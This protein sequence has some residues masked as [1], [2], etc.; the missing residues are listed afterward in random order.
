M[1]REAEAADA[2][3]GDSF[4]GQALIDPTGSGKFSER[5]G[6]EIGPYQLESVIGE[7]GFG[8]VWLARQDK[9]ISRQVAIKVI[10]AGMDTKEVL[11]RFD[12]ER[13][14]LAF[15]PGI[16]G[17]LGRGGR[18]MTP[19]PLFDGFSDR[20]LTIDGQEIAFWE[21]GSGPAILLLHGFPQCRAMWARIAPR[22]VAA[23]HRVIAADLRG[24]G[25][26]GQPGWVA[27]GH[28]HSFRAMGQ[29]MAGLMTA[30]GEVRFHVV[31]HDRGARVAHRMALDHAGR[32]RSVTLMDILPTLRLLEGFDLPLAR[33]YWH[34]TFLAQPEPF[35]EDLIAADPDRFFETCLL[36][37]G[38]ARPEDFD[39]GQMAAYRAAWRRS[40]V[41]SGMCRDYRATLSADLAHDRADRGR[42]IASPALILW[43]I[44]GVMARL[45][46]V[47]AEW[48]PYC[49]A[50][51]GE[52]LPGGHFFPDECP[53]RVADRVLAFLAEQP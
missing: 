1:L 18:G 39:A 47:A 50:M 15:G 41:I 46:D 20:C 10:K 43:G 31:A 14:A 51:Q 37:W 38:A 17:T 12:A 13:Q 19:P 23:G 3:F 32:V 6:T 5:P 48:A 42:R 4:V 8:V 40:E 16:G 44:S 7:G 29:D 36:G 52:G 26:S 2:Y 30:L 11:S 24:Y 28:S 45:Y 53:G 21:G 27:D 22:L 49:E 33:A 35:P 34:W 9:P 25:D